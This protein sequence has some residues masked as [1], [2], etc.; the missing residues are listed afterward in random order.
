MKKELLMKKYKSGE[1]GPEEQQLLESYIEQGI[2]KLEELED[3]DMIHKAANPIPENIPSQQMKERFNLLVSEEK[4]KASHISL[5]DRLWNLLAIDLPVGQYYR[6]AYTAGILIIGLIAGWLISPANKYQ[7][8]LSSINSEVHQMK[9]MMMLSMLKKTSVTERLK[10]VSMSS[11]LPSSY[12][13]VVEALFHTLNNDE[14]VN[15]RLAALE[16]LAGYA[17]DPIVRENLIESISMQESPLVQI[18]LADLMV[19]MQ[20]RKSVDELKKIME[21]ENTDPGV[22]QLLRK[23]IGQLI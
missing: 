3:L 5:W 19:E 21:K 4:A 14:N 12:G 20:E 9:E 1:I 2:I 18:Q 15:V 7:N 23:S 17:E 10:A 13:R 22:K 16:A 8:E 6:L 11:E